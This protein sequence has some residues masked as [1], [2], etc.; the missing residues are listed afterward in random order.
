M[1]LGAHMRPYSYMY[2][3]PHWDG[4]LHSVGSESAPHFNDVPVVL[5]SSCHGGERKR[6]GTCHN[7]TCEWEDHQRG[8]SQRG[9][10]SQ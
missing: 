3:A 6:Q 2:C 10:L 4:V 5:G 1:A 7:S 9:G 8:G